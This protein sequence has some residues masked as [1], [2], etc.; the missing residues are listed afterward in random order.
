MYLKED[1]HD[2]KK[3]AVHVSLNFHDSS[4][5]TEKVHM[6]DHI[7]KDHSRL[8]LIS[9]ICVGLYEYTH[10]VFM[11]MYRSTSMRLHKAMELCVDRM[12]AREAGGTYE[13]CNHV[14]KNPLKWWEPIIDEP[15]M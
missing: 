14:L 1:I 13:K 4:L 11:I 7:G 3:E 6:L 9:L 2:F 8:A 12:A 5:G 10:A 15:S